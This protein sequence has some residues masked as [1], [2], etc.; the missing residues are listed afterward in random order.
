VIL[1]IVLSY[2]RQTRPIA[3]V[4]SGDG[5]IRDFTGGTHRLPETPIEP[6]SGR[7]GPDAAKT[8]GTG[9]DAEPERT[10]RAAG[11]GQNR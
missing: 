8:E 2:F 6:G 7:A 10:R 3:I 1:I 4:L 5:R 11:D 9:R